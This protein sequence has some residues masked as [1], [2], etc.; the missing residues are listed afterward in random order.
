[1]MVPDDV[2]WNKATFRN[3]DKNRLV[4]K[5]VKAGPASKHG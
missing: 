2:G 3:I 1:M 4:S 5:F